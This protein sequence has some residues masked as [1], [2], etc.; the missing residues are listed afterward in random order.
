MMF[1]SK[2]DFISRVYSERSVLSEFEKVRIQAGRHHIPAVSLEAA[3]FLR[4]L[5][6]ITRPAKILEIGTGNAY[7]TLC[8]EQALPENSLIVSVEN[9]LRRIKLAARNIRDYSSGKIS[10]IAGMGQKVF[11]EKACF[12]FIFIDGRKNEYPE[13]LSL[14][15]LNLAPSGVF[16]IDNTFFKD[17][18]FDE[19]PP[20]QFSRL[21][22]RLREMF[23]Q[24]IRDDR[25]EY[26]I[27][28]CFD[29]MILGWKK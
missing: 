15:R 10:L 12:D 6:K 19:S 28:D 29:G 17:M 14:I 7:S 26:S 20:E 18:I 4:T 27:L 3:Q 22:P 9:D 5:V 24:I 25:I 13:Y 2:P 8:M 11:R 1:T 23:Q 21:V 16:L